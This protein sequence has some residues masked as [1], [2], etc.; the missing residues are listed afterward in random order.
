MHHLLWLPSVVLFAYVV[1]LCVHQLCGAPRRAWEYAVRSLFVIYA[2]SMCICLSAFLAKFYY[3]LCPVF[4]RS[5]IIRM[6]TSLAFAAYTCSG[7]WR[8]GCH[9]SRHAS[10]H[11]DRAP[12]EEDGDATTCRAAPH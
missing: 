12:H 10:R 4:R 6:A 1:C 5:I 9:A 8:D 3:T 11:E 2:L 7:W